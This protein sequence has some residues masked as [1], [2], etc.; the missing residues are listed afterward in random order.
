M[1]LRSTAHPS[2]VLDSFHRHGGIVLALSAQPN[3]SHRK[4]RGER[5]GTKANQFPASLRTLR[6]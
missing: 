4:E 1:R 2:H 3:R 5:N 6:P